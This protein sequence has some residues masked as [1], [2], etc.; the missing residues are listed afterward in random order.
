MVEDNYT[1]A[2]EEFSG[3]LAKLRKVVDVDLRDLEKQMEAA[4]APLTP[5]RL[6]EW[7]E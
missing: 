4:G 2:A 1:I 7:K 6:P 5:G 3:Q